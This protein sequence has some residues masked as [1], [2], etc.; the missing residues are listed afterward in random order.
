MALAVVLVLVGNDL[1]A[2]ALLLLSHV[3]NTFKDSSRFQSMSD[4]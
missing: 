2:V 4:F 1:V 3:M